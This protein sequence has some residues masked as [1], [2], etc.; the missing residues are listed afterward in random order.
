MKVI[1]R[2]EVADAAEQIL[3]VPLTETHLEFYTKIAQTCSLKSN[4]DLKARAEP[5]KFSGGEFC[6][7]FH[8]DKDEDLK[9]KTIY[10]I[11]SPG[12]FTNDQ[13]LMYRTTLWAT[14]AKEC[15]ADAFHLLL[16]DMPHARQDRG[17][18]EEQTKKVRGKPN[19]I[20]HWA[21]QAYVSGIDSII[22]THLHSDKIYPYFAEAYDVE[23]GRQ[24]LKN[25]SLECILADYILY[26]SSL[27]KFLDKGGEGIVIVGVDAGNRKFTDDLLSAL[28]LP[29]VS[30]VNFDK[31]REDANDPNLITCRLLDHSNNFNG[32]EGKIVLFADDIMDTGGTMIK[33]LNYIFLNYAG[34][35]HGFGKPDES[36]LYFTHAVLAGNSHRDVQYKFMKNF[37]H[38]REMVTTNTRP[39]ISDSQDFRFKRVSTIIRLAKLYG[40]VIL[41]H[42]LGRDITKEYIEFSNAEEQ[43]EFLKPPGRDPLYTLKRHS[44]HFMA[45]APKKDN[46][47]VLYDRD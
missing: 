35:D 4:I 39:Y 11:G 33:T 1:P 2:A 38:I 46:E 26:G 44:L 28:Y 18:L 36:M 24:I 14:A 25:V 21:K 8:L 37:P 16:T 17:H 9:G 15:G 29:N 34:A 10:G 5:R 13:D 7:Q 41:K 30:K 19:T 32:F 20:R 6:P 43:H 3:I 47:I 23:D 45:K 40:D 27:G 12:P 31:I 42:H 22:T